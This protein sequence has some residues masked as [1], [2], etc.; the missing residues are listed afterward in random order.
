MT[1]TGTVRPDRHSA[2]D[3]VGWASFNGGASI[4]THA[5]TPLRICA[6]YQ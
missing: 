4:L 1:L 5:Y 3:R 6:P 2:R